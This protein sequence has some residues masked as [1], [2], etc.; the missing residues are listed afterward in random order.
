MSQTAHVDGYDFV[1]SEY[2]PEKWRIMVFKGQA[3][4]DVCYY[5]SKVEADADFERVQKAKSVI[6]KDEST[7]SGKKSVD[8]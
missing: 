2:E 8:A 4:A 7:L 3:V 6:W 5:P 1:L